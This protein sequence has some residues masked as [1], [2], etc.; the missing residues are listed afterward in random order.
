M[1]QIID[2]NLNRLQEGL[3]V[4]EEYYRFLAPCD[5]AGGE[6][7]RLRHRVAV[8]AEKIGFLPARNTQLDP[9]K[10]RSGGNRKSLARVVTANFKRC[11]EAA[12]VL[13]EYCKVC[14]CNS[15]FWQ[16]IRFSLYEI[17]S[18]FRVKTLIDR[19]LYLI[20]TPKYCREEPELIAEKACRAGVEIIQFR[21]KHWPDARALESAVR[22]RKITEAYGVTFLINDR[23]DLAMLSCAD[24]VHLGQDDI[25]AAEAR[26]MLGYSRIIGLSVHSIAQLKSAGGEADYLALGPV[27]SCL[28]KEKAEPIVGLQA[29]N[30][31]GK[32]DLTVPLFA[33]GGISERN[34]EEIYSLG[35]FRLA[36]MTALSMNIDPVKCIRKIRKI[37]RKYESKR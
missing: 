16:K 27:F 21:P 28:S 36:F 15:G 22:I 19:E 31:A 6:L 14:S 32:L 29:L 17:E 26:K 11:Q 30:E 37:R 24:G 2:A 4:I 13:E 23:P 9:G 25:P 12:R 34:F 7:Y 10:N 33:V 18:G 5:A 8:Q 20:L 3:R 35:Q 1:L